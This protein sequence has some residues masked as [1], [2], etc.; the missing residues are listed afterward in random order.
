VEEQVTPANPNSGAGKTLH[1]LP[2]HLSMWFPTAQHSEGAAQVTEL[3]LLLKPGAGDGTA[4]HAVPF[5]R[6]MNVRV[7]SPPPSGGAYEPTA[8]QSE[9]EEQV[10]DAKPLSSSVELLGD[11]TSDQ[12]EP[13]QRAMSV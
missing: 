4:A 2:S 1:E 5:H 3:R 12:A 10:T 13:F 8:Q 6:E 9:A 11:G 7:I